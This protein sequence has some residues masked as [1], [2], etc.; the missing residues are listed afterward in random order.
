M[1]TQPVPMQQGPMRAPAPKFRPDL[2]VS[3]YDEGRDKQS[4][5]L[6][7]PVGE[8]FYRL[9]E[10]E[11]LF[12]NN[13]D[14][15]RSLDEVLNDLKEE[16]HF[17]FPEDA[18][19]IIQNAAKSGL[20]LRTRFGTA[21]FQ[22][23]HRDHIKK[24]QRQKYFT[25]VFF[26]FIP[27]L[28]PDRFLERTLWIWNL[29]VNKWLALLV[30]VLTP[31]AVYLVIDGWPRMEGQY[32]YFFNVENLL[33]LW[34]T[35]AFTK[36]IHEFAHAY[37]AKSFGLHV[38]QMGIAL[39]IF[40][41]CL[42]CNT[43]DAWSLAD[44]KQRMVIAGAGIIA[45]FVLAVLSAYVWYYTKP[46]IINSLAFYLFAVASISTL[47][48]NGNPL[49]RFDGYYALTD[50]IRTPNLMT[51]SRGF[52][53]Y[54]LLHKAFGMDNVTN[55]A[56][57]LRD[58]IVFGIYGVCSFLYRIML[59][60]A[61]ILGVYWRFDKLLGVTLAV[62]AFAIF[63]VY[64]MTK[65]IIGLIGQR[66][67]MKPRLL[68]MTVFILIIVSVIGILFVPIAR[69]SAY[70]CYVDSAESQKIT[71]PL[72][73]MVEEALIK[74][75]AYVEKGSTLLVLDTNMLRLALLKKRNER[76]ILGKR[77]ELMLL[78]TEQMAR[79][80]E[81]RIEM[82]EVQ[83]AIDYIEK[84]LRLAESGITA[85]F[86]GT[87]TELD[88]RA[89]KGYQPGEGTVVGEL[90]STDNVVVYA[91][92]PEDEAHKIKPGQEIELW[93]PIGSGL[94]F[95][96]TID[97]IRPYNERDLGNSPFSS[98]FGGDIATERLDEEHQD[99]PLEALYVC[100][101]HIPENRRKLPLGMTG[102]LVVSS[103]P[104]SIAATLTDTL[105]K[106]FNRESL[107]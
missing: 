63:G 1:S 64:P 51:K 28:N 97:L 9:S 16:G 11:Y 23:K 98:R 48:F 89:Q 103:P 37:T 36:L 8:K 35:I 101:V 39:L 27:I 3:S 94:I 78:D 17:Y 41:P 12:L 47:I 91:L 32:L 67:Q 106:T 65:S 73:T 54:L 59:Y 6:K 95:T 13:L 83:T 52:L 22:Q 102:R 105:V 104:S 79:A 43:T 18:Q 90:Q 88:Y 50:I 46:G 40:F 99:V 49:I 33:Y 66:G 58:I 100:A 92:I 74:E 86:S 14:G 84:D 75:G 10:Y 20:L 71:I 34:I 25:S 62:A 82:Q 70:N 61:I 30:A 26:L 87:V 69:K 57:S 24:A 42:Y 77:V 93:F 38:P 21:D 60:T 107:L 76:D 15:K 72:L 7:D 4:V 56:R 96:D 19:Q 5:I 31:G 85:P 55:T 53:R 2:I 81:K 45:E 44:R 29:I 68:G 80:G